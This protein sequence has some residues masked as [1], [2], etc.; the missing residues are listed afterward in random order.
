MADAAKQ[1]AAGEAGVL[2]RVFERLRP[3]LDGLGL[4]P[5]DAVKTGSDA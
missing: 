2:D 3:Y 4:A 1:V 5:V